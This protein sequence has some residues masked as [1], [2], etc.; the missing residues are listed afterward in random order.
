MRFLLY[1]P[2]TLVAVLLLAACTEADRAS[3]TASGTDSAVE[4]AAVEDTTQAWSYEG[5]TGPENWGTLEADYAMCESGE[6]QS[7]VALQSGEATG[8]DLPGLAFEYGMAELQV[9][10]TGHGF[11]ATPSREHVLRV[12]EDTYRLI[13]FH[14]HTPS[15]HTLDGTSYPAEVHFVHQNDAG[16]LA[17]VG[18]MI[19]SG[20]ANEAYQPYLDAAVEQPTASIE[21]LADLLPTGSAYLTY[22]GSLTTP[23]CTQGVRWI[24][25]SEPV[26]MSD[27]QISIL[28]DAHGETNRPVQPLE[29]RVVRASGD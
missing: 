21:A 29:G 15:E 17:V 3:D 2:T 25:L 27:E 14:A 1:V 9:E 23:P 5:A 24:V 6:Q 12:G 20:S 26:S 10:D 13:Q 16:E 4:T 11:T 18:V 19:E 22:D 28:A 8:A 7:P